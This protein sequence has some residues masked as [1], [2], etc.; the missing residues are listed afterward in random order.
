MTQTHTPTNRTL[1]PCLS[2]T[3]FDERLAVLHV[4]EGCPC[5]DPGHCPPGVWWGWLD[6]APFND[7][8]LHDVH[9]EGFLS[10]GFLPDLYEKV[11]TDDEAEARE[12]Y[13]RACEWVRTGKRG[14][15]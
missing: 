11:K 2:Q 12:A 8:D 15:E 10:H 13:E 3:A 5:P 14:T 1:P 7:A 4:L 6:D 9:H